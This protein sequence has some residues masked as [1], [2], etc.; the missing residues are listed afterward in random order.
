MDN[1]SLAHTKSN[2]IYHLVFT[3]KYRRKV[4]YGKVKHN[5]R[6][7]LRKLCDYK[8]VEIIEGSISSD[9]VHL[10]VKVPPK[11]ALSDFVGYLK[12]KSALM[13]FDAH[14]E[15]KES[16]KDRHFWSSGY[17]ADTVGRN[18]EVIVQYIRNQYKHDK[19]ADNI[20]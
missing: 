6:D 8:N 1:N 19:T 5:M 2:C 20:R 17:Y 16:R 10:C 4:M 15:F 18:E 3:P 13:I 12:G 14:P 9:H 11:I 7:I